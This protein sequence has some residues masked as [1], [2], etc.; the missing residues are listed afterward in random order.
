MDHRNRCQGSDHAPSLL[1]SRNELERTG[2]AKSWTINGVSDQTRDAVASAAREA[3]M[4]IGLWVE[5]ALAKALAEG[6]EPG[7]SIEEIEA[8]VR[9]VVTQELQAV[10]Q[11]LSRL[12]ARDNPASNVT[13][14]DLARARMRRRAR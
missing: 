1:S 9:V 5:Q 3:R 8:R 4:A 13:S 11:A 14:L 7:V 6:L 2:L 10:Q 12:E